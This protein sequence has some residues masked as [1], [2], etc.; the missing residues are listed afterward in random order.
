MSEIKNCPFCGGE[1]IIDMDVQEDYYVSCKKQNCYGY[2]EPD[3]EFGYVNIEFE[4]EEE[5]IK[6]WNT[7]HQSQPQIEPI[8]PC[9]PYSPHKSWN[10]P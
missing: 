2:V 6:A 4:T 10:N 3:G 1:A 7:R 8:D 9:S 5:A